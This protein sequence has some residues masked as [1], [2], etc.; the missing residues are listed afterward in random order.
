MVRRAFHILAADKGSK[1]Y[2][3]DNKDDKLFFHKILR[4]AKLEINTKL[5]N[6]WGYTGIFRLVFIALR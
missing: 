1:G 3:D 4:N 5:N 6:N 2:K